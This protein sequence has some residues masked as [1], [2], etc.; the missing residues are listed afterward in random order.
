MGRNHAR[1]AM[2]LRDASLE[3]IVDS[4]P[5]IGI[6]IS[7]RTGARYAASLDELIGN[8]DAAV[9]AVP[10]PAHA[11]VSLP[12]IEHGISVLVE[13]PIAPK[14]ADARLMIDAA[15][16]ADVVLMVG[17]IERFNPV[18]L[19][20]ARLVNDP[21]H[22]ETRRLSPY[23]P[24]IAEGVIMDLMIH[25]IDIVR[26]LMGAEVSKVRALAQTV[27]SET[28]DLAVA[29]LEFEGGGSATLTASRIG[30]EKIRQLAVTGPDSFIRADL[31][32]R[33]LSV[34]RV[35]EVAFD[36]EHHGFRQRGLVEIPDLA[37]HGEPLALELEHFVACVISGSTPMV[38]GDDGLEAVSLAQRVHLAAAADNGSAVF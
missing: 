36:E 25:D 5:A 24:R 6:E 38:T 27:R 22:I 31:L 23:T 13:K 19:E 12:L 21:I 16:A 33:D 20:L 37:A 15:D 28:E 4:D 30:Q 1:V 18:V 3:Y 7:E 34:H 29:L 14:V 17:H 11:E 8:V 32:R 10:T 9:V 2:G 26:S 35:E